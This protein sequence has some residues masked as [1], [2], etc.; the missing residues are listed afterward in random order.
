M[1]PSGI[2]PIT[3][4]IV[5]DHPI[6]RLGFK[7][8]LDDPGIHIV[9][10][11]DTLQGAREALARHRPQILLMDIG[12]PDGNGVLACRHICAAYPKTKIL[13]VTSYPD[14][15]SAVEAMFTGA[16]GYLLKHVSREE[17]LTAIKKA[18]HGETL[19]TPSVTD[20]I[21]G[22]L[23][24]Y[25]SADTV[26]P[27]VSPQERRVLT[28]VAEGMTNKEIAEEM[29][30]SDKT[31]R[32][33]LHRVYKKLHVKGRSHATSVFLRLRNARNIYPWSIGT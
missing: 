27:P 29:G 26:V 23:S 32:N 17:L 22:R 5:D 10:E 33:Y 7:A 15:A 19:L 6:L 2:Q 21:L 16:A 28:L 4:L 30:L 24:R 9:A 18:A 20:R 8:M 3:V 14:E 12:L 25:S 31:V 11:V 13:F 1:A